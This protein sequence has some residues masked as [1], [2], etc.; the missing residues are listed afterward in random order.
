[1]TKALCSGPCEKGNANNREIWPRESRTKFLFRRAS[2]SSGLRLT[3]AT[4]C[5]VILN[6]P[7]ITSKQESR[8]NSLYD[9]LIECTYAWMEEHR[10][11]WELEHVQKCA[12]SS[13][14]FCCIELRFRAS[15]AKLLQWLSL[16]YLSAL[17]LTAMKGLSTKSWLVSSGVRQPC[18]KLSDGSVTTF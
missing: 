15:F 2:G 7:P 17:F 12:K 6:M 10:A 8:M 11:S 9:K 16:L 1:M 4:S 18:H 3:L 5:D 14:C 13:L